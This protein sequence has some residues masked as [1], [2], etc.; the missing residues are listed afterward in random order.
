MTTLS[1]RQFQRMK[2]EELAAIL[3]RDGPDCTCPGGHTS[4]QSGTCDVK[5]LEIHHV[6]ANRENW[7]RANLKAWCHAC[8]LAEMNMRFWAAAKATKIYTI[9]GNGHANGNGHNG[10]NHH[11]VLPA[12]GSNG[13]GPTSSITHI[14]NQ[15]DPHLNPCKCINPHTLP[16]PALDR[17][18]EEIRHSGTPQHIAAQRYS[19]HYRYWLYL[20]AWD[21]V[22]DYD[23][24]IY[25]GTEE[26][27]KECKGGSSITIKTYFKE[28]TNKYNGFLRVRSIGAEEF[29]YLW[30]PVHKKEPER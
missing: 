5:P 18:G 1:R 22:L 21:G 8:N 28:V 24:A 10:N 6:D 9:N 2:A 23:K 3:L 19:R 14:S 7:D 29:Y 26:V 27:R 30:C 16:P 4:H 20:M 15:P 13:G 17:D 12:N 11:A 25:G